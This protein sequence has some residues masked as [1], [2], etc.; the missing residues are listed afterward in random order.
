MLFHND[1][2]NN[3]TIVNYQL[4]IAKIKVVCRMVAMLLAVFLQVSCSTGDDFVYDINYEAN[5]YNASS[6]S[7]LTYVGYWVLSS[8]ANTSISHNE[9]YMTEKVPATVVVSGNVFTISNM[10]YE[11]ILA[12]ALPPAEAGTAVKSLD[13][14]QQGLVIT[15]SW[16]KGYTDQSVYLSLGIGSVTLNVSYGGGGHTLTL[17]FSPESVACYD[18]SH[19]LLTLLLYLD[20]VEA[21]GQPLKAFQPAAELVF[22][23]VKKK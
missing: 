5:T 22:S 1:T 14:Q 3:I 17:V 23:T 18:T 15:D 12:M 6:P 21:D 4:P 2:I 8:N 9:D 16:V 10:P 7:A 20:R 11:V 13:S 19:Q